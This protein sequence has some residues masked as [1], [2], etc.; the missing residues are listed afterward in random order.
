M[1]DYTIPP[2]NKSPIVCMPGISY[3]S[4]IMGHPI[5]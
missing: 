5:T 1:T 2:D 3:V 4:K